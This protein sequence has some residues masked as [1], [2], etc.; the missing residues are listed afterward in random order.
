M[1]SCEREGALGIWSLEVE[2]FSGPKKEGS[3]A[4]AAKSAP[5]LLCCLRPG[6]A[7]PPFLAVSLL[8]RPRVF[9]AVAGH[10]G[11]GDEPAGGRS[12]GAGG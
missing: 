9:C 8:G 3:A 11:C 10:R 5:A 2:T 12:G 4:V 7:V 6:P 1:F